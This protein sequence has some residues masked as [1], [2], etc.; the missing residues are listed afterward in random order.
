MKYVVLYAAK[1]KFS[2]QTDFG[3]SRVGHAPVQFL[4]SDWA[5]LT[6]EFMQKIYAASWN[7]FT[8]TAETDRVLCPLLMFL[9]VLSTECPK[10]N[11]AAIKSLLLFMASL[12]IGFLVEKYVAC[13]T[14]KSDFGWHRF[15][16]YLAWCVRG[17]KVNLSN[18]KTSAS[19]VFQE[20]AFPGLIY[21]DQEP[22]SL[23]YFLGVHIRLSTRC[24]IKSTLSLH[25]L[26]IIFL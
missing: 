15:C 26:Q 1:L 13:E 8:L 21:C 3:R 9:T 19:F 4:C 20:F 24:K 11:S 25:C 6:G 2:F 18:A 7:L 17:F 16:F 22:L 23:C 12:F 14:R 5:N 10:W